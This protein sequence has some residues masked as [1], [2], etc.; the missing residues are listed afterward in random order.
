MPL[1]CIDVAYSFYLK[2]KTPSSIEKFEFKKIYKKYVFYQE[3]HADRPSKLI[4]FE[5]FSYVLAHK[6]WKMDKIYQNRLEGKEDIDTYIENTKE[7]INS[8]CE[9]IEYYYKGECS[10]QAWGKK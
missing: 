5:P 10:R 2:E 3:I 9:A 6:V 4:Y 8:Y 7:Y 1:V